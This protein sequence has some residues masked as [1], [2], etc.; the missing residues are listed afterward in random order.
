MK[1][2]EERKKKRKRKGV[3]EKTKRGNY[4]ARTR[5]EKIRAGSRPVEIERGY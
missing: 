1:K 2:T 3:K 5:S 4:A